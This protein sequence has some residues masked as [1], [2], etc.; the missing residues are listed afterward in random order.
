MLNVFEKPLAGWN[1]IVKILEDRV[2]AA[3]I[4]VVILPLLLLIALVIK[5][6]SRGP[7]LFRQKR[8]GFNNEVIEVFKFRSM[9]VDRCEDQPRGA[10]DQARPARHPR[11]PD[12]APHLAR[13][14]AAV[15]QRADGHAC[16]S[17]ARAPMR[18][19]TTSSTPG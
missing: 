5:L 11:R 18:S 1:Y 15:P 7:V 8:Y 9:H 6:D 4:L 14:A 10:G 2:L 16:R 3:V 12:P 17:S 19:P 13:R